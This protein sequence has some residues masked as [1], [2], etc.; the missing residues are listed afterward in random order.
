MD[1]GTLSP[2][3]MDYSFVDVCQSPQKEPSREKWEIIELSTESHAD[4][5]PT[6]NGVRPVS[7]R[8]SLMTLL[9]P[10]QCHAAFRTIHSTLAWVDQSPIHQ[11]VVA[12]LNR[13]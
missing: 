13:V 12:T 6:Y 8:G 7:P 5:R 4:G 9:L 10:P 11:H 3:P 2:E 1:R